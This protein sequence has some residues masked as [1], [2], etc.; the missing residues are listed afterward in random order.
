MTKAMTAFRS[1]RISGTEVAVLES[2]LGRGITPP[3]HLLERI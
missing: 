1:G 3:G 2:Y